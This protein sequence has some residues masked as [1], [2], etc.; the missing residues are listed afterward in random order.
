MSLIFEKRVPFFAK[1]FKFFL[2]KGL[3]FLH[4]QHSQTGYIYRSI[5]TP[6]KSALCRKRVSFEA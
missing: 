1:I 3:Y 5:F 2:L 6:G 4:I